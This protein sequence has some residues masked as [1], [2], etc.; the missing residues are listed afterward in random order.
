MQK[1]TPF[2]WFNNNA[3]EA[4][5]FYI[6]IFKNSRIKDIAFYSEEGAKVSGMPQGS[7]MTI[8]FELERQEF[9]ALNGGPHFMINPAISF[10]VDCKDQSE[11]D[12]Y[13]EKLSEGGEQQQ[14]G[15][16]KDKFGV[17]WQIVPSILG[18]MLVDKDQK[19][20]EEVMHTMLKMKRIVIEDLKKAYKRY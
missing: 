14:C 19:K 20:S 13:W 3:E 15:W 17:S 5:N 18:R 7:I 12:Y 6:S 8:S 2:L 9:V 10:V 4:A 16:V 11:V 1:I